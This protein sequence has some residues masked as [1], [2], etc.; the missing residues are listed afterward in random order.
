MR[1]KWLHTTVNQSELLLCLTRQNVLAV[2]RGGIR[3]VPQ[4]NANGL[5]YQRECAGDISIDELPPVAAIQV[6]QSESSV[7]KKDQVIVLH[8]IEEN[9]R[10]YVINGAESFSLR[11]SLVHL[12]L[13]AKLRER[14]VAMIYSVDGWDLVLRQMN[15][16]VCIQILSCCDFKV[17][18]VIMLQ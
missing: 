1:N 17:N 10:D 7:L 18:K 6:V 8:C 4:C 9:S 5:Y 15:Y 2:A 13:I 14:R 12:S 11:Y 3:H 16:S